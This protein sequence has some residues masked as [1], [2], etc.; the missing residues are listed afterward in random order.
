MRPKMIMSLASCDT[1][2]DTFPC[3]Y[4]KPFSLENKRNDT[5]V[6]WGETVGTG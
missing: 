1:K 3:V 2:H 6:D 4:E 5:G